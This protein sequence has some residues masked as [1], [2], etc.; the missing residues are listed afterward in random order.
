MF[1]FSTEF[2]TLDHNNDFEQVGPP[3]II[4]PECLLVQKGQVIFVSGLQSKLAEIDAM[5][6]IIVYSVEGASDY[7][8]PEGTGLTREDCQ[9]VY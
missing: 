3:L 2:I 5:Y 9:K 7:T 6:G 4:S 8:A 1:F